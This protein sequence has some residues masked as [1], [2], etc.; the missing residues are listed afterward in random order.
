MNLIVDSNQ[1]HQIEWTNQSIFKKFQWVIIPPYVLCEIL[2]LNNP[3]YNFLPI[4]ALNFQLG[5]FPSDIAEA[6]ACLS[7]WQI[8]KLLPFGRCFN[9]AISDLESLMVQRN[10]GMLKQVKEMKEA[11]FKHCSEMRKRA[12][13][14][15]NRLRVMKSSGKIFQCC[16]SIEEALAF[17][18]DGPTS[19]LGELIISVI[20]KRCEF[21]ISK[22]RKGILFNLVSKHSHLKNIF[23]GELFYCLAISDL[24][25]PQE[26]NFRPKS[27]RDDWTD[28]TIMGLVS[29]GD[30]V[31]TADKML[32]NMMKF[33]APKV[34]VVTWVDFKNM[35]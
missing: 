23:L 34:K 21:K 15:Q 4:L 17:F 19:F 27:N 10:E 1:F 6:L 18:G 9:K 24:I 2:L 22:E 5:Y 30:L 28:Q 33:V 13:S 25:L 31:L 20:Q 11:N 32:S 35:A 8:K 7:K 16:S 29:D 3:P 14:F 26:M 12:D